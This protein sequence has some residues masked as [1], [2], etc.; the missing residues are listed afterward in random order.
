MFRIVDRDGDPLRVSKHGT[1]K[2]GL[3]ATPK[4]ARFALPH[5]APGARVQHGRVIWE[6][7]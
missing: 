4:G 3:Y 2:Q 5:F 1:H 6:E 7:L